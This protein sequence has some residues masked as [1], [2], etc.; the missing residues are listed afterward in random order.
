[1]V[2]IRLWCVFYEDIDDEQLLGEYRSLLS[3][4]EQTQQQRFLLPADRK[5]YVVTRALLRTVLSRHFVSVIAPDQWIFVTGQYGRPE[6]ARA[7]SEAK[8]ISFSI[9]HT[10]GLIILGIADRRSLGVDTEQLRRRQA[11]L[12][13]AQQFF[14]PAEVETLV[15]LCKREREQR[16]FEYWTLKESYI[17]A[18]GMGLAIPL[19]QFSFRFS[20]DHRIELSVDPRQLD[21]A[22]RWSFLQFWIKE[23]YVVA[24]CAERMQDEFPCLVIYDAVP[25]VSERT[26]SYRISRASA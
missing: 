26:L 18:R 16:F 12:E 21:V 19:D 4:D 14:A 10:K 8:G 15:T 9:S 25:M 24:V 1:M 23:R 11:L 22:A 20:Q 2:Q 13:I 5:R 3:E 17:K 6:I 7:H